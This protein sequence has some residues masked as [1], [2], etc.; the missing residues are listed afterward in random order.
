PATVRAAGRARHRTCAMIS[1]FN[2]ALQ[3]AAR[4]GGHRKC[5]TLGLIICL[6]LVLGCQK[7]RGTILGK[8]PAGERRTVL[9]VHAGETPPQVK[10]SG[11]MIEKCPV[12]GCWFRLR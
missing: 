3:H 12:A 7:P 4:F 11:I 1:R 2:S 9:S 5:E 6:S 10:L 8:A